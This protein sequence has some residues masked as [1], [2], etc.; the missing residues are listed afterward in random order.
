M[1]PSLSLAALGAASLA[2]TLNHSA[3]KAVTVKFTDQTGTAPSRT[4]TEGAL[5]LSFAPSTG[6]PQSIVASS[7]VGLCLYA[8]SSDSVVRCGVQGTTTAP[9]TYNSVKMSPNTA[10][11]FRGGKVGGI[12][13]PSNSNPIQISSSL[14][15]P[16]LDIL[17]NVLGAF[18]LTNPIYLAAGDELFFTGSGTNTA[19]RFENFQFSTVPGPSAFFGAAAAFGWSRR[20]RKRISLSN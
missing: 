3:A 10:V 7:P 5:T 18:T 13:E 17:P 6:S 2:L 20:L 1:K 15:G 4:F 16:V 9:Q 11:V 19:T 14:G 12:N 8:E